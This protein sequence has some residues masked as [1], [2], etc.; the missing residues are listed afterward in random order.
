VKL[1]ETEHI[2]E[3]IPDAELLILPEET[4]T[5]YTVHSTK[6]ADVILNFVL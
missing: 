5:S 3:M 4:H 2:A 6:L 1:S